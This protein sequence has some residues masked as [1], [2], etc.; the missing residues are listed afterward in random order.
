MWVESMGLSDK[1][2]AEILHERTGGHPLAIE[3]L[4]FTAR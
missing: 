3:L 1:I 4:K 2:S